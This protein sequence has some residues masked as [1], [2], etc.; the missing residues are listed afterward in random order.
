KVF[1][2]GTALREDGRVVTAGGRVLCVTALGDSVTEAARRAY[3]R[4]SQIHWPD[5]YYRRDIGHRAIA[6]EAGHD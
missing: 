4:V 3:A 5:A 2:A 1:H 6:R